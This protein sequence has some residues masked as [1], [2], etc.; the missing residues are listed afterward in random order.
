MTANEAVA[1]L[2]AMVKN[3]IDSDEKVKWLLAL[4]GRYYLQV[5]KPYD[6]PC[7][8]SNGWQSAVS[9]AAGIEST[10]A[11]V[12]T[13]AAMLIPYPY[14]E[15]YETY[16]LSRLYLATSEPQRFAAASSMFEREWSRLC[17]DASRS[18]RQASVHSIH[19]GAV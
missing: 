9:D 8:T 19:G 15:I 12:D 3:N 13:D 6:L 10:T 1:S 17:A 18:F 16:L 11:V 14:S 4:D 2:D 5:V 7:D